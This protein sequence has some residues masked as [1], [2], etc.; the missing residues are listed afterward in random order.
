METG[1]AVMSDKV[2]IQLEIGQCCS[3]TDAGAS[4]AMP[5]GELPWPPRR[6]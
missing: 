5:G 4:T 6:L 2:T 1:G 3:S